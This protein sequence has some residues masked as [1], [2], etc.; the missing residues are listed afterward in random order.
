MKKIDQEN[1]I[2]SITLTAHL[3]GI[4]YSEVK[5]LLEEMKVDA[6]KP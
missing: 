2:T 4:E 5:S 1:E 3:T 6:K